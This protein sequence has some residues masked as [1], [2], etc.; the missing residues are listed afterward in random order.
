MWPRTTGEH[1]I[2]A[3]HPH[4]Q[5]LRALTGPIPASDVHA[6]LTLVSFA[7]PKRLLERGAGSGHMTANLTEWTDDDAVIHVMPRIPMV[8]GESAGELAPETDHFGKAGKARFINPLDPAR[9]DDPSAPY[10]FVLLHASADVHPLNLDTIR[11]YQSLAAGGWMMWLGFDPKGDA[12]AAR[13]AIGLARLPDRVFHFEGTRV[14]YLQKGPPANRRSNGLTIGWEGDVDVVHSLA[15]VNRALVDRLQLRGHLVSVRQGHGVPAPAMREPHPSRLAIDRALPKTPDVIVRHGW[16]PDLSRREDGIPV[17]LIQPWEFGAPPLA[18]INALSRGAIAEWWVPSETVRAGALQAG[19]PA[20]RVVVVP[21]GVDVSLF[22]PDGEALRLRTAKR[23]KFLFVGGTIWRK[24]FDLLLSAF[25]RAFSDDDDV[26]LV[27]KDSGVGTYYQGQTAGEAIREFQQQTGSPELEYLPGEVTD[28]EMAQLYRAADCLVLPYRGEGFGMPVAEAMACGRTVLVTR[29]GATDDWCEETN[30]YLIPA[31][32]VPLPPGPVCGWET[33]G[34]AWRLEPDL[35]ALIE[36]LRHIAAHPAEARARGQAALATVRERLTWDDAARVIESR[37]RGLVARRQLRAGRRVSLTMIVRNEEANLA[38]CL[39][40][41]NELFDEI[42]I[43]DTGSTDRTTEI[44]RSFGAR[45]F[46]HPWSDSFADA[47]NQAIGHATGEWIF[48]LDADDRLDGENRRRLR[49][50]FDS[51]GDEQTAFLMTCLCPGGPGAPESRIDHVRLFRRRDDVRWRHRVHEQI[52]PALQATGAAL[53]WS[54]VIITHVGYVDA[55]LVRQKHER[56]GRLLEREVRENPDH[57]LVLFQ[58]GAHAHKTRQPALAIESLQRCLSV[59]QPGDTI[60]PK[61]HLLLAQCHR[62][63]NQADAAMDILEAGRQLFPDDAGLLF[64]DATLRHERGDEV[65]A[66]AC[67]RRLLA[68]PGERRID[69]QVAGWHGYLARHGLARLLSTGERWREA[70][71][72]WHEALAERPDFK[73]ARD[74]L[75]EVLRRREP[76]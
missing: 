4:W 63:L 74:S 56:D 34:A 16:P 67:Y 17:A 39:V 59:C 50:L 5:T 19:A 30:A 32:R 13:E 25:G 27:V 41:A 49:E 58:L 26:C 1:H 31:N 65:G 66:E 8:A 52:L 46:E 18:W 36:Q 53:Q 23:F 48:W 45:V 44:A 73:P 69:S 28:A 42:V 68:G 11:S 29:G 2:D 9:K 54:D 38:E 6:V 47:R 51:L 21:N 70:V 7:R 61:T 71:D 3:G 60:L 62:E 22:R 35:T 72:L 10:D 64:L 76:A 55:G 40:G 43:V 15:A 37:V 33:A 20:D 14:A 57:P 75:D 24:G 12:G